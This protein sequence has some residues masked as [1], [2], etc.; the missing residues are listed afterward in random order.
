[1]GNS[2]Q[3]LQNGISILN[4]HTGF[5]SVRGTQTKRRVV[6]AL[7]SVISADDSTLFE[8]SATLVPLTV[9]QKIK[10][11]LG[12]AIILALLL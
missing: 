2:P 5:E 1:M 12:G 9:I 7:V 3:V 4:E 11:T 8:G 10:T 6:L